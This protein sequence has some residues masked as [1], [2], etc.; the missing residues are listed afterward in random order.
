M[1]STSTV[2]ATRPSAAVAHRGSS[3]HRRDWFWAL[4]F[5][6]PN[7]LLFLGFTLAPMVFGLGVSFFDWNMLDPPRFLG[8]GNYIQFFC[9][10]S[11]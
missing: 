8:L 9:R 4:F 6:G 10:R 2:A 11:R 7:L 5:L 1:A 3:L